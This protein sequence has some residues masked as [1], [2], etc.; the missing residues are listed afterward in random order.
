[1][2]LRFF[3]FEFHSFTVQG[4]EKYEQDKSSTLWEVLL[5]K[6][7]SRKYVRGLGSSSWTTPKPAPPYPAPGMFP[8]FASTSSSR[9]LIEDVKK[10]VLQGFEAV[11]WSRT[12]EEGDKMTVCFVTLTWR[13]P[14]L[15]SQK[16]RVAPLRCTL[17]VG[18]G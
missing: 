7:Y 14:H 15:L 18:E 9:G 1:M 17:D 6:A 11:T 13:S 16:L 10:Q 4:L 2:A 8:L 3:L 5:D 12:E